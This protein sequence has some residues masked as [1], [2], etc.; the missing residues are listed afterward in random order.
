MTHA[1]QS[2]AGFA[3]LHASIMFSAALIAH[4]LGSPASCGSALWTFFGLTML[5][6]VY[7]GWHYVLDDLAGLLIGAVAVVVGALLTGNRDALRRRGDPRVSEATTS[8][9]VAVRA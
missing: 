8:S 5:A 2:V 3:S 7:F 4:L 1:V 9:S 6:T